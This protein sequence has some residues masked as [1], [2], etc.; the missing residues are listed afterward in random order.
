MSVLLAEAVELRGHRRRGQAEGQGTEET[1]GEYGVQTERAMNAELFAEIACLERL[2]HE[3]SR[4]A[5]LTA[6]MMEPGV[7]HMRLHR[8]TD[9]SRGNLSNHLGKLESAGMVIVRKR[10]VRKKPLT[11][12][13]LTTAGRARIGG[14]WTKLERLCLQ[15]RASHEREAARG[16]ETKGVSED[17]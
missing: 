10:F 8:L 14:H 3:P 16:I 12:V 7:S 4:L 13:D 11:T 15:A 9:I 6:V 1:E 5:I 2:I 17:G